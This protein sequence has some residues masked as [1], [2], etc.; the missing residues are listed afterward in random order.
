M[1]VLLLGL[2]LCQDHFYELE[3]H[4]EKHDPILNVEVYDYDILSSDDLIGKNLLKA[5]FISSFLKCPIEASQ[6][7]WSKLNA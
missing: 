2:S 7:G 5:T 4:Y 3:A 6:S 1:H